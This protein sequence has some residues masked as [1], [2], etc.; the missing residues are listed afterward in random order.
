[1]SYCF[2]FSLTGRYNSLTEL[3]IIQ[4]SFRKKYDHGYFYFR[5]PKHIEDKFKE[6]S[7]SEPV[8][9]ASFISESDYCARKMKELKQQIIDTGISCIQY[10]PKFQRCWNTERLNF[11][12]DAY[13][14]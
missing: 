7:S 10:N 9:W 4:S 14:V 2:D 13:H 1:M 3:E 5:D 6:S 11:W 8:D 12:C